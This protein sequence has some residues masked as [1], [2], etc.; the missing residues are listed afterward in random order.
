V[1]AI[2][3]KSLGTWLKKFGVSSSSLA[4]AL[5]MPPR[6]SN[7][8]WSNLEIL[9][10]AYPKLERKDPIDSVRISEEPILHGA[11][12]LLSPQSVEYLNL[13]G[14]ELIKSSFDGDRWVQSSKKVEKL[15]KLN[16]DYFSSS[17]DWSQKHSGGRYDFVGQQILSFVSPAKSGNL[18]QHR[19]LHPL[20][21]VRFA[22]RSMD[23]AAWTQSPSMLYFLVWGNGRFAQKSVVHTYKWMPDSEVVDFK[24]CQNGR[25]LLFENLS[26]GVLRVFLFDTE[27]IDGLIPLSYS[28]RAYGTGEAM[29]GAHEISGVRVNDDCS[30]IYMSGS[31]GVVREKFRWPN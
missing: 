30:E 17:V 10:R 15:E 29:N 24:L 13:D 12:R 2:K 11:F 4:V 16:E 18:W 21:G 9:T 20:S 3:L 6:I 1:R 31:F 8:D 27:K 7:I 22:K 23:L 26:N 25:G 19:F 28:L 14:T 5:A